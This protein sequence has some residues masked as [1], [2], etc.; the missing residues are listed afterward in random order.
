MT[1]EYPAGP[2]TG[3]VLQ[4]GF[5]ILGIRQ[6]MRLHAEPAGPERPPGD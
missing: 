1:T 2:G 6:F 3:S 4:P 5:R